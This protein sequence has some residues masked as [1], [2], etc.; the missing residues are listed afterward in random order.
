[1]AKRT[2]E[3]NEASKR[4]LTNCSL[5]GNSCSPILITLL[6][7][8]TG[9]SSSCGIPMMAFCVSASNK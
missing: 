6:L 1:M 3:L 7:M 2:S 5:S 9:I 4:C 8:V